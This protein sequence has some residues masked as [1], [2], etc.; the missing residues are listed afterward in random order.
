MAHA[1]IMRPPSSIDLHGDSFDQR[2][3]RFCFAKGRY[4]R[5]A[6][7]AACAPD[8]RSSPGATSKTI[9]ICADVEVNLEAK[10]LEISHHG[11]MVDAYFLNG[12]PCAT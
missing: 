7:A 10:T 2:V 12:S 4:A 9:A 8:M 1:E 6:I 3:V 5:A 11:H